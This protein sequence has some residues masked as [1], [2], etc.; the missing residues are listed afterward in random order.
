LESTRVLL[1]DKSAIRNPK[2]R[3]V[4]PQNN[5]QNQYRF[6]AAALLSMA[7]LFGWQYFFAPTPPPVDN[8]NIA[9]NANV[10][11]PQT[12]AA[13]PQA[14]AQQTAPETV[15]ATPDTTPNRLITIKSPLYEVT[16][17]SKGA[18]ATS[19]IL[20]KNVA[21]DIDYPIYADG[22]TDADKKPLQLISQK[23]LAQTPRDVPFRLITA[24]QNISNLA[25]ER[26][27]QVS[28][29]ST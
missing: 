12:A 27:Y 2:I 11:Q 8:A 28:G 9:A 1:L 7:V 5:N 6:F 25:N 15:Q 13:T 3:I 23:A 14:P 24:D 10:A 20:M 4:E 18:V 21:P 16:L 17:D 29:G 22:S 19:W 26:N